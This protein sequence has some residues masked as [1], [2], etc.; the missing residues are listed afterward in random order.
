MCISFFHPHD[1]LGKGNGRIV[2]RQLVIVGT[3]SAEKPEQKTFFDCTENRFSW[4]SLH[5]NF[6]HTLKLRYGKKWLDQPF[7]L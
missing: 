5:D 7:Y 3:Q 1:L 4:L 2:V 6:K